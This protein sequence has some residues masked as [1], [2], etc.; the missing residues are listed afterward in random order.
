[1]TCH[2]TFLCC[3]FHCWFFFFM[4]I[5]LNT[6]FW[7]LL[8]DALCTDNSRWEYHPFNQLIESVDLKYWNGLKNLIWQLKTVEWCDFSPGGPREGQ[9][10]MGD[11]KIVKIRHLIGYISYINRYR[12]WP[13]SHKIDSGNQCMTHKLYCWNRS[14]WIREF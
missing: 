12:Y 2:I 7:F 13:I 8:L 14:M 3:I 1:M 4:F 9:W 10:R 6:T 5:P 11:T